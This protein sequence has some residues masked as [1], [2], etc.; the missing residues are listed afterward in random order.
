MLE[1]EETDKNKTTDDA[2]AVSDFWTPARQKMLGLSIIIMAVILV[3]GFGL[4]FYKIMQRSLSASK[5]PETA[6]VKTAEQLR[7][8]PAF[9]LNLDGYEI[10]HFTQSG[11]KLSIYVEKQQKTQIWMIDTTAKKI[12]RIIDI[13]H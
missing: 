13:T 6:I 2:A 1:N 9:E 4:V 3:I 8:K 10:K 11:N 7:P 5:A 12:Y